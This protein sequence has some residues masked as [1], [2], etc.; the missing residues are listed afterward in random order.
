MQVFSP[1]ELN[2]WSKE[3]KLKKAFLNGYASIRP[4]PEY[5]LIIPLL[6]MNRAFSTIGFTLK[7]GTWNT[8]NAMAYE[9]NFK[10]L[11]AFSNT[12]SRHR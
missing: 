6:L 1:L 3:T 2:E 9:T 10:Y 5:N 8:V 12:I 7:K 4:I 11:E